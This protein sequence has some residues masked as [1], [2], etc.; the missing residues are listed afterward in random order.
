MGSEAQ[1]TLLSRC[2][3]PRSH[4]EMDGVVGALLLAAATLLFGWALVEY[5]RPNPGRWTRAESLAI[6]ILLT[7]LSFFTFGLGE[8][9]RFVISF[10]EMRIGLLQVTLIAVIIVATTIGIRTL[11][12]HWRRLVTSDP[13]T[14]GG[15]SQVVVFPLEPS[16]EDPD[17]GQRPPRSVGGGRRA[18]RRRAA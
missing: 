9:T 17:P 11:R 8:L 3:I 1:S 18:G 10:G 14:V 13:R 4:E 16:G 7:A 6:V 15:Q 5:R 2:A 12:A